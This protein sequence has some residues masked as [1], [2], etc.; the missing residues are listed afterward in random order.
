MSAGIEETDDQLRDLLREAKTIAVVGAKGGTSEDAH[1]IPL[2]MQQAGYRIVPVNPILCLY[3]TTMFRN[4]PTWSSSQ[5]MQVFSSAT[6]RVTIS[7]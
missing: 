3:S 1:R 7:W 2:Y 4:L 6:S 5:P